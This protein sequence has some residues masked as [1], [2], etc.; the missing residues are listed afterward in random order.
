MLLLEHMF[1]VER[2]DG[3]GYVMTFTLFNDH[4]ATGRMSDKFA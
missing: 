3:G 4:V 1:D 2:G